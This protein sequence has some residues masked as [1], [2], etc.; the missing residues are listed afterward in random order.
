QRGLRRVVCDRDHDPIE[1]RRR[2][3]RQVQ[4]T[5]RERIEAARE[6]RHTPLAHAPPPSLGGASP[7]PTS[8][9]CTTVSPYCR[10]R[11]R[12]RLP[13]RSGTSSFAW[14][15]TTAGVPGRSRRGAPSRAS[16]ARASSPP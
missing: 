8:Y 7:L 3:L 16:T 10:V 4:V 1:E 14:H 9:W 12:A 13:C 15:S 5:V 6:Q 2:A 11:S